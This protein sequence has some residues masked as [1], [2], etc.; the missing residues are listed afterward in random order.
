MAASRVR[1]KLHAPVWTSNDG[2]T[3]SWS[4]KHEADLTARELL[5]ILQFCKREG[6]KSGRHD[7]AKGV[8]KTEDGHIFH[9]HF[10]DGYPHREWLIA[11]RKGASDYEVDRFIDDTN[12]VANAIARRFMH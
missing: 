8:L 4:G 5:A 10:C 2:S 6:A 11:Y 7:A 3:E 9:P 1:R 12:D